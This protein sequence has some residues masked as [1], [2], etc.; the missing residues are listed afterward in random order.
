MSKYGF[1]SHSLT[2][3]RDGKCLN[4]AESISSPFCR[5]LALRNCF[6]MPCW[7]IYGQERHPTDQL[8]EVMMIQS[9]KCLLLMCSF[10]LFTRALLFFF[11]FSCC[12]RSTGLW[13]D[14]GNFLSAFPLYGLHLRGLI[15][16]I[17]RNGLWSACYSDGGFTFSSTVQISM[18]FQCKAVSFLIYFLV[19]LRVLQTVNELK[20]TMYLTVFS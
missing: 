20:H 14:G 7:I 15:K 1:I 8:A 12:S 9:T 6:I 13:G 5:L 17:I 19:H 18:S 2:S 11:F 16:W 10:Q 3:C 4:Q